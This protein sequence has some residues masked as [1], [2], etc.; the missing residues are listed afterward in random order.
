MK[1]ITIGIAIL[2]LT[3][4]AAEELQPSGKTADIVSGEGVTVFHALCSDETRMTI[5]DAADGIY[6][7]CWEAGDTLRVL[8]AK[9]DSYLGSAR[10]SSG[11]GSNEATFVMNGTIADSTAVKLVYGELSVPAEQKRTSAAD[12]HVLACAVSSKPVYVYK[13]EAEAFVMEHRESLIKISFDCASE[14]V[15]GTLKSVILRSEGTPVSDEGDYVRVSLDI[16][17]TMSSSEQEIWLTSLPCDL[18]GSKMYIAFEFTQSEVSYTVPVAFKGRNLAA[19]MVHPFKVEGLSR[20]MNVPW[21]KSFDMRSMPGIGYAYGEA[22]CYFIQ[23]KNGSTYTGAAYIPNPDVPSEVEISYR[24]H[25]DFAKAV[26]PVG[27]SFTWMKLGDTNPATGTGDGAVYTIRTSGYSA[28]G[29]DPTK[30]SFSV[31]EEKCSVTVRN[32]GAFAGAPILLMVK[33]GTVLWA[34]SFW[35]V[36]ADGTSVEPIQISSASAKKIIPMDIGQATRNAEAWTANANPDPIWRTIYRYQ[37]GRPM[38]VF[39][40]EVVTLNIPGTEQNA[41]NIAAVVGPLTLEES[42]KH[43]ASLIVAST[44]SGQTLADWLDSPD[45]SLWGNCSSDL[46][47]LGVKSVFDPCPK[48]YRI[49]DRMTLLNLVRNTVKDWEIQSGSGYAWHKGTYVGGTDY[50]VRS[51]FFKSTTTTSLGKTAIAGVSGG[52]P[53]TLNEQVFWWTNLCESDSDQYPSTYVGSKN[54]NLAFNDNWSAVKKAFA[55]SVR[56][57]VDADYR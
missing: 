25:G 21:F 7:A 48:G 33:D 31:N 54:A 40:N 56:C 36:A 51:G 1:R 44:E 42:L 23:C 41:G 16:P 32:D 49:C 22:N 24:A 20:Y 15:G 4:C 45:G 39:W 13:G 27:V 28:S 29:V 57:E 30:F 18:S 52:V 6:K 5:G 38:P 19:N 17:L 14:F 35:N 26:I 12:R 2:A 11:A 3:A 55:G 34:W 50:W 37:W 53:G 10:I 43:P 47:N 9:D 46:S 8:L